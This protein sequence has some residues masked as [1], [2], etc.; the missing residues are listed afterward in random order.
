MVNVV[1]MGQLAPSGLDDIV[2]QRRSF[3][4][5]DERMSDES[6]TLFENS[7]RNDVLRRVNLPSREF[8]HAC[9]RHA[10]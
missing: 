1:M 9:Q 10:L 6:E 3:I 7:D 2:P 8:R 4:R 5:H